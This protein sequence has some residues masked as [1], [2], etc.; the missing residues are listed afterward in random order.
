MG[1]EA[2]VNELNLILKSHFPLFFA[3]E[4]KLHPGR[5]SQH[6]IR[7]NFYCF[8]VRQCFQAHYVILWVVL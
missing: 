3:E 8:L 1:L 4:G 6:N 7:N 5:E 2:T